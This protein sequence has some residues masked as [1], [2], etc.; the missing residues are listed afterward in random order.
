MPVK[1]RGRAAAQAAPALEECAQAAF[2]TRA[3]QAPCK[4]T[5]STA[6]RTG[7]HRKE[8]FQ[9]NLGAGIVLWS[10]H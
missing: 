4:R 10:K 9:C 8:A 7:T 6:T 3:S 5:T 1:R 2:A